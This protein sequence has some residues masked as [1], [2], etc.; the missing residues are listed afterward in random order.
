MLSTTQSFQVHFIF[1]KLRAEQGRYWSIHPLFGWYPPLAGCVI[2]SKLL[3]LA[4]CLPI[5]P[6]PVP[7]YLR[8][9]YDSS[10]YGPTTV[11]ISV[12]LG[13]QRLP[14]IF[15]LLGLT[16]PHL[17]SR[18]AHYF[19]LWSFDRWTVHSMACFCLTHQSHILSFSLILALGVDV[20]VLPKALYQGAIS[21]TLFFY[22][23]NNLLW[24]KAD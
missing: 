3:C 24:D 16:K 15:L 4:L 2:L 11:F 8:R 9:F 20:M 13:L 7:R 23:F 5:G 19:W 18:G 14:S 1:K 10:S 12:A 22:F 17:G 21:V 6:F